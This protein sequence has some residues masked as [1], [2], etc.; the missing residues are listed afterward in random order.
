[1]DH[2]NTTGNGVWPGQRHVLGNAGELSRAILR[3]DNV[4]QVPQMMFV[5]RTVRGSMRRIPRMKMPAAIL[6]RPAFVNVEAVLAGRQSVHGS[7][8]R[9]RGAGLFKRHR[10]I[11]AIAA[12]RLDLDHRAGRGVRGCLSILLS[13]RARG[14]QYDAC[15]QISMCKPKRIRLHSVPVTVSGACRGLIQG[16]RRSAPYA[17]LG[18]LTSIR[19]QASAPPRLH[20]TSEH[21]GPAET[22]RLSYTSSQTSA[23]TIQVGAWSLARSLVR[24]VALTSTA[25][26]RRERLEFLAD[27]PLYTK[28]DLIRDLNR[29]LFNELDRSHPVIGLY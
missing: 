18:A 13:Q 10:S 24:N 2:Q 21:A 20:Q 29:G 5:I 9:N 6:A 22:Y 14:N 19:L 16:V 15:K 27:N 3:H 1:M 17:C 25:C 23:T 8:D 28:P 11:D 4:A 7:I 26:S 12:Q